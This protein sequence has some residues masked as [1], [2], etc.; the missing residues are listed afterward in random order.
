MWSG[1]NM[2][3]EC[4][5]LVNMAAPQESE[6]ISICHQFVYTNILSWCHVCVCSLYIQSQGQE[7]KLAARRSLYLPPVCVHKHSNHYAMLCMLYSMLPS[8]YQEWFLEKPEM[9]GLIC[10][11]LA[12]SPRVTSLPM[13]ELR[14]TIKNK[15]RLFQYCMCYSMLREQ[16]LRTC[17]H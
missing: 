6:V 9:Q 11:H 1:W 4:T 12:I 17:Q 14:I 3:Q 13:Q 10:R 15:Y 2:V 8:T 5:L 16:T 7:K